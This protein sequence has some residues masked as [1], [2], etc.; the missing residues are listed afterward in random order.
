[1]QH[2][3]AIEY[4]YGSEVANGWPT[5]TEGGGMQ[6]DAV[7][8]FTAKATRDVWVSYGNGHRQRAPLPAS[9]PIV[10]RVLKVPEYLTKHL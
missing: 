4:A 7:H 9:S 6:A 10:R 2:Y 1:M 5:S 8:S 3:Y